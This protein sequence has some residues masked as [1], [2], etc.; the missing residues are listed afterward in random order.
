MIHASATDTGSIESL[1]Y[2]YL[3]GEPAFAS[4]RPFNEIAFEQPEASDALLD[5]HCSS[6]TAPR[7][8]KKMWMRVK[9]WSFLFLCSALQKQYK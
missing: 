4:S 5:T 8:K 2:R 6:P 1:C 3:D 7:E 9:L